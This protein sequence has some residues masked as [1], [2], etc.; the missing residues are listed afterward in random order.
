[1]TDDLEGLVSWARTLPEHTCQW[2]AGKC[3]ICDQLQPRDPSDGECYEC[4]GYGWVHNRV[5]KHY[6]RYE[7]QRVARA[8]SISPSLAVTA[9][10]TES[11]TLTSALSLSQSVPTF[12]DHR[13]EAFARAMEKFGGSGIDHDLAVLAGKT[14]TLERELLMAVRYQRRHRTLIGLMLLNLAII[15]C[16]ILT[17]TGVV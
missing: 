3:A 4:G 17:V 15:A 16:V 14:H 13:L 6:C 12:H 9:T 5:G 10:N 2:V 8:E 7:G 11:V 1:M